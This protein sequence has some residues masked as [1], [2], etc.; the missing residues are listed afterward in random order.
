MQ[1]LDWSFNMANVRKMQ[2]IARIA[3]FRQRKTLET[4][5]EINEARAGTTKVTP[6][7]R[8][9]LKCGKE[10]FSEGSFNRICIYCHYIKGEEE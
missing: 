4:L 10:F 9:C 5:D 1:G 7:M 2:K 8:V 3:K 6:R